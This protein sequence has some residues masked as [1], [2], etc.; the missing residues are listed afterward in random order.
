MRQLCDEDE[1]RRRSV[2]LRSMPP[3]DRAPRVVG[4]EAGFTLVELMIVVM[5]VGVLAATA[6]VV[7]ARCR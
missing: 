3:A 6:S 4:P 2:H 7:R 5:I 1:L